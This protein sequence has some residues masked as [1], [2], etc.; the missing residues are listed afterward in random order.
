[1][2]HLLKASCVG[3]GLLALIYIGF[4]FVAALYGSELAHLSEERLL[5]GI[6]NIILGRFGGLVV[7]FSV[8]LSC[9]TTA[10]A[11]TVVCAEFLEKQ[12]KTGYVP[13]LFGVIAVTALVSFLE[14]G[15]IQALMTPVLI[16]C[17]PA[18]LTLSLLNLFYKA[19]HFKPVKTP[20]TIVFILFLIKTL[21]HYY[22]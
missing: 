14:F 6:G 4:A 18:L 7:C 1:M 15:G 20:V 9:L 8:A 19:F 16:V 5:G 11:L 3:A 2:K 17:Y 21:S 10:I 13:S 22:S 12:L